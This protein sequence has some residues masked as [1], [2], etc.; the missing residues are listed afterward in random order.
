MRKSAPPRA[1][2]RAVLG[3]EPVLSGT[4]R[5]WSAAL[6]T[7]A[8]WGAGLALG[9][10]G[11]WLEAGWGAGLLSRACALCALYF[12]VSQ[13]PCRYRADLTHRNRWG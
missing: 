4:L 6:A 3:L 9:S 11:G 13:L 10:W 2:T 7:V 5:A 12:A 1:A 8:G